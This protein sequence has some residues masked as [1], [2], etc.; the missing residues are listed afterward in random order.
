MGEKGDRGANCDKGDVSK[1]GG[2]GPKGDKGDLGPRGMKEMYK[3]HLGRLKSILK[4]E[5][6]TYVNNPVTPLET[7]VATVENDLRS[8]ILNGYT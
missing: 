3:N 1:T 5:T 2:I 8:L 7:K 6:L 4:M